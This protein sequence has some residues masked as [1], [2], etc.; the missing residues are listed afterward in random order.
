L[1]RLASEIRAQQRL[2]ADIRRCLPADIGRHC[3][4]AHIRDDVLV[5]HLSS[6]AWAT[7]LRYLAPQLVEV[8]RPEYPAL[9]RIQSRLLIEPSARPGAER[10]GA[11]H[12]AQAADIIHGSAEHASDPGVRDALQRLG[13]AVRARRS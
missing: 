7:R 2:L 11:R 8:L 1:Q 5:V 9:R 10:P 4:S 6:P 13:R 12:S 3:L